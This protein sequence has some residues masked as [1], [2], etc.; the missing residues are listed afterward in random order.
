M[1]F[2]R[3]QRFSSSKSI[4]NQVKSPFIQR[5]RGFKP[6]EHDSDTQESENYRLDNLP[7]S[8]NF[9]QTLLD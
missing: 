4:Q 6:V 2:E 9:L 5:Q 1:G 8:V 3:V 7:K